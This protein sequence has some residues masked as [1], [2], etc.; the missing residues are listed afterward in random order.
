MTENKILEM[1]KAGRKYREITAELGISANQIFK[2]AEAN[3]DE[4]PKKTDK[5]KKRLWSVRV[6]SELNCKMLAEI[7]KRGIT[8]SELLNLII[9]GWYGK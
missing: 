5:P 4:I 1:L 6:S 8:P 3:R 9:E 2:I 7:H